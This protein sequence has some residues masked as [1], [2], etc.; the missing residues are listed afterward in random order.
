LADVFIVSKLVIHKPGVEVPAEAQAGEYFKGLKIAVTAAPGEKCE[1][2]WMYN[3][4][5]GTDTEHP[6]LCPRCLGVIK[7]MS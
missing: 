7:S 3:E 2:C 1:R 4:Q 5:V 6:A